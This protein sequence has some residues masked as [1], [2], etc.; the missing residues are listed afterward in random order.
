VWREKPRN[1]K[2]FVPPGRQVRSWM[3]SRFD[4]GRRQRWFDNSDVVRPLP[5]GP[6][7][8]WVVLPSWPS[9]QSFCPSYF[10]FFQLPRKMYFDQIMCS[11]YNAPYASLYGTY[12]MCWVMELIFVWFRKRHPRLQ[13][14]WDLYIWILNFIRV[15]SWVRLLYESGV[16]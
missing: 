5:F 12:T 9:S 16:D 8:V 13:M 11:H 4:R 14:L 6:L 2:P 3:D 15:D 7:F 1:G 10:F